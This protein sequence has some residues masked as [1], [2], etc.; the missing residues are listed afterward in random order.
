MMSPK[1]IS[2]PNIL[3]LKKD[4]KISCKF[5]NLSNLSLPDNSVLWYDQDQKELFL[6]PSQVHNSV[7]I[8][9]KTTSRTRTSTA[10]RLS[11]NTKQ[12]LMLNMLYCGRGRYGHDKP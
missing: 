9:S 3:G 8:G 7:N 4:A 5:V 6:Y 11:F 12:D 1:H 10:R 2:S